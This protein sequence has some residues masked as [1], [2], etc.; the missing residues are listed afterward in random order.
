MTE[1]L[2]GLGEEKWRKEIEVEE[3]DGEDGILSRCKSEVE[4]SDSFSTKKKPPVLMPPRHAASVQLYVMWMVE[5][6]RFSL[7]LLLVIGCYFRW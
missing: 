1:A 7:C 6:T 2:G 3:E 4:L 5:I